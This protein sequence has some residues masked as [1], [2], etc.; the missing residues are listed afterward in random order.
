MSSCSDSPDRPGEDEGH[1]TIE[2]CFDKLS[3]T[4]F[5]EKLLKTNEFLISTIQIT[6]LVNVAHLRRAIKPVKT[7]G[8]KY[9]VSTRQS[10]AVQRKLSLQQPPL[11]Y[12][13]LQ[14]QQVFLTP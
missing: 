9:F 12:L 4:S 7:S 3:I 13:G 5:P 14:L 6:S 10:F 11:L 8:Y 2:L 1:F